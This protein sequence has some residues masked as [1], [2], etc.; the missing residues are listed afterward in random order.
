M[1]RDGYVRDILSGAKFNDR[2]RFFVKG[3]LVYEPSNQLNVRLIADYS[4][5][6][7]SCCAA[8]YKSTSG[9][10]DPTPGVPGDSTPLAVNPTAG[11][12]QALGGL[13][14]FPGQPYS[15]RIAITP[16]RS[17]DSKTKDGGASGPD[18]L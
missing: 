1:K 5:K 17:Y 3:Q 18:R 7:E 12:I 16:G 10:T 6:S 13:F 8:A 14:P 2:D 4:E 9:F 15:Y 11:L